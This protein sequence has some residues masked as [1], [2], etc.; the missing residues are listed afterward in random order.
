MDSV[1]VFL[2]GR[3]KMCI[4]GLAAILEASSEVQVVGRATEWEDGVARASALDPDVIV[5]DMI[6]CAECAPI[7]PSECIEALSGAHVIVIGDTD[8]PLTVDALEAGAM[9]CLTLDAVHPEKVVADILSAARGEATFDP[10]LSSA[11]L[12]RMRT[13]ARRA[14]TAPQHAMA[15]TE[16]EA[17]ILELLVKGL[18]NHEI[19][20]TLHVSQSTVK[21]HL[22]AIFSKLGVQ[23]RSQAVSEAIRRGIASP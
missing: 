9:G 6:H 20:E 18:S 14:M 11:V 12:K 16:R 13:H 8:S 17:E 15:P 7:T 19:A 10:T 1:R 5:V 3:K 22:H 21:N 2:I 4:E 23:S